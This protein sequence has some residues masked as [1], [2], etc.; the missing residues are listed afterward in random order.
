MAKPNSPKESIL[1]TEKI[2]ALIKRKPALIKRKP[3]ATR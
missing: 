3:N 1:I 2:T